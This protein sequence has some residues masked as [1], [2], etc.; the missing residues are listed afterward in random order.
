MFKGKAKNKNR[1]LALM[2]VF[3]AFAVYAWMVLVPSVQTLYISFTQWEGIGP[4]TWVG[5]SNYVKMFSEEEWPLIKTAL[6]NNLIWAAVSVTLPVWL[7]LLLASILVRGRRRTAK[8]LQLIYF[9]PQVVSMVVAA[10]AWTWLYNPL[11]GPLTSIVSTLGIQAPA[12]LLGGKDTVVPA[13]LVVDVW[14]TFGFCCLIYTSAIQNI[15]ESVYDAAKV[16]GVSRW[17]EFFYITVPGV[18]GTTTTLTLLMLIASFKVFDLVYTMT[19][20][21]PANSSMVISLYA[22]KEGFLYNHMGYAAAVT[23]VMSALLLVISQ[24]YMRLRT[25]RD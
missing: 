12:G 16:D 15:D 25:H 20:G 18:R 11:T 19:E 9:L 6:G 8:G 22:Y 13:L 2:L 21:G 3:P 24:V 1:L 23:M 4:K 14:L 5:L 17:Q 7:G 10:V